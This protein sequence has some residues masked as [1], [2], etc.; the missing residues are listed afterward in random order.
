V[1]STM[2]ICVL[3]LVKIPKRFDHGPRFLGGC[4]A[5]KIDKRM[6]M[7][8][9]AEDWEIF[10]NGFPVNG[11]ASNFVHTIICSACRCTPLLFRNLKLQ[12]G[13]DDALLIFVTI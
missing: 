3:V 11:A 13:T 6:A 10:A 12:L 2:D 1:Q 9:F 4:G 5:I 7:R 8:L